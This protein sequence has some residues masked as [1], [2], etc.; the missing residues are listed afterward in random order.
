MS[1]PRADGLGPARSSSA[2]ALPQWLSQNEPGLPP[3][4]RS[5]RRLRTTFLDR[6]LAEG[7]DLLRRALSAQDVA[8]RDGLLQRRDPRAKLLGLFVLLLAVALVHDLRTL[9]AAHL[10]V[11]GAALASRVPVRSFLARIWLAVPA[12]T[13]VAVLPATLSVVTP[14]EVLVPL[15]SWHGTAHGPTVQGLTVAARILLR[16]TTSVSLATLVAV[17]TPWPRLLAALRSLGLPSM[18]VLVVGM[19][20]RYLL[21]LLGSVID[22]Y[23]ARRAR[24]LTRRAGRRRSHDRQARRFLAASTGVLFGRAHRMSEEV[25]QA[26]TA[27]GYRGDVPLPATCRVAGRDVAALFAVAAVAAALLIGDRALG[28]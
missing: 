27:R 13:A 3:C 19:A 21:L 10:L 12:F 14:G 6:T 8:T 11:L 16:A 20:H 7:S 26:M 9:A 5:G 4:E 22:L 24:T 23:Q 2:Q 17:T 28:S 15:W 25:H 1:V 18:F